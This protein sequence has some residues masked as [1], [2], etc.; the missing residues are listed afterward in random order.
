VPT[1]SPCLPFGASA[2]ASTS[3]GSRKRPPGRQA[4]GKRRATDGWVS[5]RVAE[6]LFDL[7]KAKTET[8]PLMEPPDNNVLT[9]GT[10]VNVH[11]NKKCT[12]KAEIVFVGG[13]HGAQRTFGEKFTV[14]KGKAI[15]KLLEVMDPTAKVPFPKANPACKNKPD[16][17]D[18]SRWKSN[19]FHKIKSFP[20]GPKGRKEPKNEIAIQTLILATWDFDDYDY[21]NWSAHLAKKHGIHS[22][23]DMMEHFY[24]NKEPWKQHVKMFTPSADDHGNR[25]K[26]ASLFIETWLPGIFTAEVKAWLE[27]YE[28]E[29]REGQFAEL[30]D[31][32]LFRCIGKDAKDGHMSVVDIRESRAVLLL[33]N[34]RMK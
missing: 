11:I 5:R 12:A 24:F 3:R 9:V 33:L 29:C 18:R 23:E 28:R 27:T 10:K 4:G 22:F 17:P 26:N 1:C 31:V 21:E 2:N 14:G 25:I 13:V 15:V 20:G 7:V 6:I 16:Y 34:L 8:G 19:L 32:S 30:S